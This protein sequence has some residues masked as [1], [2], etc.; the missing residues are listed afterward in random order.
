MVWDN[1]LLAGKWTGWAHVMGSIHSFIDWESWK[2]PERG[3]YWSFCFSGYLRVGKK[4]NEE[5]KSWVWVYGVEYESSAICRLAGQRI[6]RHA[7]SKVFLDHV[8]VTPPACNY[9]PEQETRCPNENR[10][11]HLFLIIPLVKKCTNMETVKNALKC[12]KVLRFH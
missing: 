8:W 10:K 3:V 6:N 4:Q 5:K 12:G 2:M 1:P 9:E 7:Q 11:P